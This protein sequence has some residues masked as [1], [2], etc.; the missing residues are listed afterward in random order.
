VLPT[1]GGEVP[2]LRSVLSQTPALVWSRR[3]QTPVGELTAELIYGREL[4]VRTAGS[5]DVWIGRQGSP[6]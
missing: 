6:P 1:A 3:N 5:S 4:I 2:L